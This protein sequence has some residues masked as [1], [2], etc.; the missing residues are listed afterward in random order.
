MDTVVILIAESYIK[1]DY[2]EQVAV[3]I[4]REVFA[5]VRSASR[6]EWFKAAQNDLQ[7]SFMIVMPIVNY[8]NE[9]IVKIGGVEYAVY[10]H[11]M[12]NNSDMVELYCEEKAGVV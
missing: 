12:Q 7:A 9:K 4:E 5:T 6:E 10:R 1:N 3:K 11:Y 8:Q 2:G